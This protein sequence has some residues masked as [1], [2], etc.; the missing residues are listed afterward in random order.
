MSN[1]LRDCRICG[2]NYEHE[3]EKTISFLE[4]GVGKE[5]VVCEKCFLKY[6]KYIE[7]K[8]KYRR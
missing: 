8:V 7:T 2:K 4:D 1:D 3:F 6:L 5:Y